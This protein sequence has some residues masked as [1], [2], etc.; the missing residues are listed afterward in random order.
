MQSCLLHWIELA[1]GLQVELDIAGEQ[2]HWL[3]AVM[4]P[5]RGLLV[6]GFLLPCLVELFIFLC[7]GWGLC[8]LYLW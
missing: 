6:T 4:D 3:H 5:I 7:I 2:S 8:M 1:V